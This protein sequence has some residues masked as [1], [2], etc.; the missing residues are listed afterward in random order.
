MPGEEIYGREA[1]MAACDSASVMVGNR[2]MSTMCHFETTASRE[3]ELQ[4][5]GPSRAGG[6]KGQ[7]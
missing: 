2:W 6:S 1:R 7:F 3:H 4:R 5:S